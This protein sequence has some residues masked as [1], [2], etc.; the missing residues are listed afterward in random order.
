MQ[1]DAINEM[2]VYAERYAISRGSYANG[3][4]AQLVEQLADS[5]VLTPKTVS[6]LIRDIKEALRDDVM[7]YE[8]QVREWRKTLNTLEAHMQVWKANGGMQ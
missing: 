5:G 8:D 1:N 7:P 6:V 4:M 2:I 3:T